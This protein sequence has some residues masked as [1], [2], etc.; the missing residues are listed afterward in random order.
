MHIESDSHVLLT[1]EPGLQ[2]WGLVLGL[3]VKCCD[4][5]ITK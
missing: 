2:A 3:L 5:H 1:E 4:Q